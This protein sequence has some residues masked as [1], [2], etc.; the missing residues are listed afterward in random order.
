M[1]MR[2]K[3]DTQLSK[4]SE[5][6]K[7]Y[8]RYVFLSG[9]SLN[10]SINEKLIK[11]SQIYND[12]IQANFLD[13][14]N[15]LP[16]KSVTMMHWVIDHCPQAGIVTK[17]DCDIHINMTNLLREIVPLNISD[18]FIYGEVHNNAQPHRNPK[19]RYY[20]PISVYPD[21]KWK[22]YVY[23]YSY[24]ITQSAVYKIAQ[25]AQFS[26]HFG[27]DDVWSTG[28]VREIAKVK[29]INTQ[30]FCATSKLDLSVMRTCSTLH[31]FSQ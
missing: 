9:L 18:T 20:V 4:L 24:I 5:K 3:I 2:K 7:Q 16:I 1:E 6:E 11:E 19:S 15:N 17:L 8:F 13:S 30:N 27:Q 21:N 25:A 29:L 23:G 14:Y 22:P 31:D 26:K 28:I 12:I 10:E